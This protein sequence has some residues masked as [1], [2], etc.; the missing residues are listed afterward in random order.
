MT[1][2]VTGGAGYVGSHVVDMLCNLGYDTTAYDNLSTG[3]REAVHPDAYFFKGDIRDWW[4][5]KEVF[6]TRPIEAVL[7]LAGNAYV[8]ESFKHPRKYLNDNVD[9]ARYLLDLCHEFKVP[10][11]VLAS[12]CNIYGSSIDTARGID[13]SGYLKTFT[14]MAEPNPSSPY[15]ESKYIIER[16]M[17]W[18]HRLHGIK[19]VS[20]R[21][22]NA[23]GAHADGHIGEDHNPET[24]IIPSAIRSALTGSPLTVYGDGGQVRDFVHVRDI[25]VAHVK[26]MEWLDKNDKCEVFNIGTGSG[27]SINEIVQMV[28]DVSHI[29]FPVIHEK[30]RDGDVQYLVASISKAKGQLKY[31]PLHDLRSIIETAYYWHRTHPEGYERVS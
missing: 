31:E 5:L 23:A 3:H 12:S 2:L 19:G 16:M 26:A 9:C 18:A 22:F 11:F 30:L 8:E 21:F 13:Y 14:E 10:K 15:G 4:T 20:L 6:S 25:A 29:A 28:S 1:I 7:H 24:H 27:T 17:S